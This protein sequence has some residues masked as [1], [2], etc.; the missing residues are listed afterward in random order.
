MIR[1]RSAG[2]RMISRLERKS[3]LVRCSVYSFSLLCRELSVCRLHVPRV[4]GMSQ[5]LS[6]CLHSV[7]Y[8]ES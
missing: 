6:V 7:S 3:L 5:E 1:E 4:V 8:V 2:P